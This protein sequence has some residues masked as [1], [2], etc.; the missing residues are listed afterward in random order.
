M[1]G[2]KTVAKRKPLDI[3]L[4]THNPS[5]V[6]Q[7][8]PLLDGLPIKLLTMNE[9]GLVGEAKE[10]GQ[11]LGQNALRK[12]IFAWEQS[13]KYCIADDTG[14]FID[15]L[16]GR[17]GIHAARWAGEKATTEEIM[18]FTLQK[19]RGIPIADRTATFKT[20]ALIISPEKVVHK[21]IG[22]V[23]GK[24]LMQP[25]CALQPKMPYSAIFLPDGQSKVWAEMTVAEEN[26]ISH[27]AQAFLKLRA[28]L[29]EL[30]K[31][32]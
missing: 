17:P 24:I 10:D 28:Y 11:N 14:L 2:E 31:Q 15:A 23:H 7:I 27:R 20:M 3:I 21:F 9:A 19:L 4:A 5:K 22:S 13:R 18:Q 12:A 32:Q 26:K 25:R 16:G 8:K 1:K 29:E 6:A 30:L